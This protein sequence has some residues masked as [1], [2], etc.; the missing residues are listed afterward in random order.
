MFISDKSLVLGIFFSVPFIIYII[1]I[2]GDFMFGRLLIPV[3]P[4]CFF[5][6][7]LVFLKLIRGQNLRILVTLL[8]TAAILLRWH[9]FTP[10]EANINGIVDEWAFYPSDK[11]AKMEADGLKLNK[12]LHDLDVTIGFYGARAAMIYYS[13]LPRA[14]E[15]D[16]G[17]TDQYIAHIPLEYR[18]RPGHE[19][20]APPQYLQERKVNFILPATMEPGNPYDSL[21]LISFNGLAAQIWIYDNTVMDRL[22]VYPEVAF[23]N[24]GAY[25]DQYISSN[26]DRDSQ[27]YKM[28][29]EFFRQY[30]FANNDDTERLEKLIQYQALNSK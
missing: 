14:I 17:L 20:H 28:N 23:T 5:M 30:Y 15:C 4:F 7:E 27:Q 19:K 6:I 2:G 3:L 18:G 22:S 12:Y 24:F 1:R 11:I 8:F 9:Q 26:P 10:P 21:T 13:D 29:M 25:L 16:A